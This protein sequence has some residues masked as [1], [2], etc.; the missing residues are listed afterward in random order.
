MIKAFWFALVESEF[1]DCDFS[2]G[3]LS[4]VASLFETITGLIGTLSSLVRW[5][6][7]TIIFKLR[8]GVASVLGLI[9]IYFSCLWGISLVSLTL[10]RPLSF[11]NREVTIV[12][13]VSSRSRLAVSK[14][15]FSWLTLGSFLWTT[16]YSLRIAVKNLLA[17]CTSVSKVW[18]NRSSELCRFLKS[19]VVWACTPS[20]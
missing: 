6:W 8:G 5:S 13:R 7:D 3:S 10:C 9:L 12:F 15:C 18:R 14:S 2:S 20:W 4:V 11:G 17:R 1:L 16:F 19:L